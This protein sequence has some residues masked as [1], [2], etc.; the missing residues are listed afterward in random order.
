MITIKFKKL[1]K[2]AIIPFKANELDAGFDLTA[3]RKVDL[4]DGNGNIVIGYGTGLCVEIP[5]H[6]VGLLFP[7]SSIC[8]TNMILTNSVGDRICQLVI[9][10]IPQIKFEEVEE[11]ASSTRGEKGF[12]SSGK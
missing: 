12:G 1:D 10:P 11:L 7:R 3:T 8:K 2:N 6:H 5:P 9:I 4:T